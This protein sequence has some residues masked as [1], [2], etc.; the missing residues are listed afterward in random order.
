[1]SRRILL[2]L[3]PALLL[4]SCSEVF[5]ASAPQ[6][7]GVL[8]VPGLSAPVAIVRDRFGV[9]HITAGSDRDL[10]FAQ[11]FVHAQ[12]RLFQMDLERRLAR[13]ELAELFGG[14][15]LPAD[16]LFR[17]LGFAARAP[18]IAASWP[19]KTRQIVA[20]YCAGI[21]AAM[22]ALRAWP[23]ESR[24]LS[25]PPRR[26]TPDDVAAVGLLKS[27]GLSQ[28]AEEAALYR[29][30]LSLPREKAL[31]LL[32]ETPPDAPVVDPAY[33]PAAAASH[34]QKKSAPWDYG[35]A[36]RSEKAAAASVRRAPAIAVLSEG[37]A[38]LRLTAGGL[39]R[40]GGSNAWA[41][42]GKKSVTGRPLLANDPHILL[43]CPSLWYENHLVAPGV[44]VYGVSFPGAPCV[45]IGHNRAIAWGFTNAMLDDADFFVE[46]LDGDSV[47][48][49]KK[50]IPMARRVE[51]IRVR[52]RKDETVT[53]RETP[54]GPILSPVFPGVAGA[55]SLRWVGFDGGDPVGAL[56]A[57]NRAKNREEFLAA[58]ASF[59]HPAQ[60]VVYADGEGNIGVV[61]IGKI[62]VRKGGSGQLPVPG[63]TGEWE[64]KGTVPFSGNPK[65]WNP[66]EG[67]VAAANFP[68][69]GRSYP[70][71]LSRLY[72]PPDRG[73][74]IIR[75]LSGQGPL[76]VDKFERIQADVCRP[77]AEN[78]VSL[79]IRS[80]RRRE[81]RSP[82]LREAA[83]ILSEWNLCVSVDSP[84]AALYETFS[85][86]LIENAFRDDMG[87][88]LFEEV[89]RTSRILWN[90][91]DRAVARG[92]SL[93]FENV[94]TGRKETLDELMA[95]SLSD[96]MS[97]L[98]HRLGG[99][100]A[101]WSWGRLHQVTFEHPFGRMRYLRRWF[102]IG[103]MGVPG[104]GRTVFKEEFR[105]GTDFS[106][107]VGP[108]MRQVVPLGFRRM[109]RSVVTTGASGHFFEPHYGDQSAL[110]LS[111]RTHPAWTDGRDIEANAESRLRLTP[112]V[113]EK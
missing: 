3:A 79:A 38:A 99:A 59:P 28:W 1:M 50:W 80:A 93:F 107:V 29:A 11:G 105:H 44:D 94:E 60:N 17:H 39:P 2:L 71:Y 113:Q 91:M 87:T 95:R 62:P 57:I 61:M 69:A 101:T 82:D 98:K 90:A 41:V 96:A 6:R 100:Y 58:A 75:L 12:D 86:K 4:S 64:W 88:A 66:P 24:I 97:S 54:H 55:L 31:E 53:V 25:A 81:A 21:N 76:S 30:W 49:R 89:S 106:V 51:T 15:A 19:P 56:H 46:K 10:Y 16:R 8:S 7:D 48:F 70:H 108:S 67:F 13:G 35:A 73:K 102:N 23:A 18:A 36:G 33:G 84:G 65:V 22:A 26:F 68:P 112:E 20:S 52:G 42:S 78:T 74:R 45:V 92:D 85:E 110:W 63:D 43:T 47:M 72:E 83:R 104:D 9:P 14:Q 109:A 27:L 32:P 34:S 103:P 37:L 77:E 40:A 5:E 111:G